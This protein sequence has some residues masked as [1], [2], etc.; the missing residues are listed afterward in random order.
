MALTGHSSVVF[1]SP[2]SPS[3]PYHFWGC[4]LGSGVLIDTEVSLLHRAKKYLY[5]NTHTH[6][7]LHLYLFLQLPIY[8]EYSNTSNSNPTSHS[9]SSLLLLLFVTSFS[10]DSKKIGF[11][12]PLLCSPADMSPVSPTNTTSHWSQHFPLSVSDLSGA[13]SYQSP[14]SLSL[15]S[16]LFSE[17]ERRRKKKGK[18]KKGKEKR[19]KGK[20]KKVFDSS[21]YGAFQGQKNKEN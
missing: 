5:I 1:F 12:Y 7:P 3:R 19:K 2:C 14:S 16:P 8:L 10:S 18:R 13:N 9:H 11:H 20:K 17:I 4:R 21:R 15:F 6:M